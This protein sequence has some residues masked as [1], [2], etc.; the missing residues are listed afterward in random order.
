MPPALFAMVARPGAREDAD[1][2]IDRDLR[3]VLTHLSGMLSGS[4]VDLG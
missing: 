4:C 3:R 1:T 2:L